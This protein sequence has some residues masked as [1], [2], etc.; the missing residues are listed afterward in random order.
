MNDRAANEKKSCDLLDEWIEEML[1]GENIP[2]KAV[3]HLHCTAHVLLGFHAYVLSS[4][5]KLEIISRNELK[6]PIAK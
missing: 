6:H 3:K 2:Q 5:S 1:A 4:L